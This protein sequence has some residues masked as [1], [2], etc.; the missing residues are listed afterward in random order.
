MHAVFLFHAIQHGLDMAILNP[1]A[2]VLYND[3]PDDLLNAIEDLIFN[4]TDNATE[5]VTLLA[6]Q[7]KGEGETNDQTESDKWRNENDVNLRLERA[8]IKGIS[9]YLEEDINEALKQHQ[10]PLSIIEGPLM[11]AM[12]QIGD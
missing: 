10:N 4:R 2:K 5:R 12:N 11:S 6:N 9:D 1:A 7:L 3:I 8:I